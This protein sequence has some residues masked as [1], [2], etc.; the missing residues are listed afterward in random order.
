[1]KRYRRLPEGHFIDGI[2]RVAPECA[3]RG[4]KECRLW[5]AFVH[6]SKDER[7]EAAVFRQRIRNAGERLS[8]I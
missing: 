6:W 4:F 2:V 1:M 7:F 3:A 8:Y 5:R